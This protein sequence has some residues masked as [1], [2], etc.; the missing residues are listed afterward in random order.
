MTR[1][2]GITWR[3]VAA[4]AGLA[5]C[6]L[7][8]CGLMAAGGCGGGKQAE[9]G[10][11]AVGQTHHD[12][13]TADFDAPDTDPQ[14]QTGPAENLPDAGAVEASNGAE[15]DASNKPDKPDKPVFIHKSPVVFRLVNSADT[16]LVFSMDKGWQPVIFAYSGEPPNA[17]S[18]IMF[19]KHCT[20]SCNADDPC[21]YCPA[22]TTTKDI[23][24]AEKRETV[25]PGKHLDVEWDTKV[26][27][28]QKGGKKSCS[29]YSKKAVPAAT[30]TVK[31]CGLR[32]T[33]THKS[34]TIYQCV[35]STM[36]FPA[37]GS[38]L[39]ELEFPNPPPKE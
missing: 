38:Q 18:I 5:V 14:P 7:A 9:A 26:F 36:T 35:E 25:A 23:K 29:C 31:A 3:T 28:Y 37:Q 16:D 6:G 24:A 15:T 33:D 13:Q 30:Y 22:P 4:V 21:P 10:D 20:A 32:I 39:V 8:V 19:A 27:V 17:E 11:H 1:V 12:D 2:S 34:A